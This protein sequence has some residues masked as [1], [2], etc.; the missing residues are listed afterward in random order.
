[1]DLNQAYYF[2]HV[3][4]KKGFTAASKALGIP[5]S[6]LSRQVQSLE[7]ALETRLMHRNSRHLTLT[8]DGASYY[9]HA[10]A[11][12]ECMAAAEA[13]VRRNSDILTGVATL[14]CS[15]GVAQSALSQLLPQFMIE[16]PRVVVRLQVSN[17]FVDMLQEGVDLAV[18]GHSRLLPDS[19]YIQ[20]RL[21][22]VPWRLFASPDYAARMGEIVTPTDLDGHP[23]LA[24]GWRPGGD[25]W[26]L[27][28]TA[29][30]A[31]SIP[32]AARLRCDDMTTLKAAAAAGLGIV[33]L[34]AYVCREEIERKTLTTL[35]PDWTAGSPELS[36]LMPSRLGAPPQV[37]ALAAF[38][39]Q[40][41]PAAVES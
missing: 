41:F 27:Q 36:L 26:S 14:S 32:Y 30:T 28:N 24:L 12:L 17:D 16:N 10:K 1:M 3:V 23:G 9:R 29:G 31:A 11:A 13:A 2:V 40:K 22:T 5:K 33:A 7:Q 18:R 8:E 25:V 35:L 34:P 6:R 4:E 19:D 20:R 39:R 37:E 21:A 38:L 15:I